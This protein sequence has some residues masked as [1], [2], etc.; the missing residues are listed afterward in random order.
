MKKKIFIVDDHE[1][2]RLG[3]MQ[4]IN[5]RE[6]LIVCGEADNTL[7]ALKRIEEQNPDLAIVDIS[8]KDSNGLELIKDIRV[9]FPKL[10]TLVLSIY[11]ESI[12]AER[13]LRA[14]ASGY[15]MKQELTDSVILAIQTI[16]SGR[17]YLSSDMSIRMAELYIE[18]K[19]DKEKNPVS[20]LSDREL[21]VFEMFGRGLTTKE[22]SEK[23][24]L[25]IKTIGNYRENIKKKLNLSNTNEIVRFAAQ[26]GLLK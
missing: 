5:K 23:L 14:G 13:A 3:L 16:L 19:G 4:I 21:E 24:N 20:V 11:D 10:P 9:R 17:K 8:L 15:I 1:I 2:V 26:S 18:N 7:D 22:I 12:Y 25:S 6:N